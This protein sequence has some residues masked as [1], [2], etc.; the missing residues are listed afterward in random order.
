MKCF[1]SKIFDVICGLTDDNSHSASLIIFGEIIDIGNHPRNII[2]SLW[3]NWIDNGLDVI[4]NFFGI[5]F[6]IGCP[7]LNEKSIGFLQ[8]HYKIQNINIFLN[9]I[10]KIIIQTLVLSDEKCWD[11]FLIANPTDAVES[12]NR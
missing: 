10:N 5:L 7:Y 8:K 9:T 3:D 11:L 6:D 4:E 12:W 1:L 2:I